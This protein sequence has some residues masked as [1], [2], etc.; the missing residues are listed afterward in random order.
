MQYVPVRFAQRV[1]QHPVADE[2]AVDEH[3]LAGVLRR[4]GRLHREA[5]DRERPRLGF[6]R[7]RP[8]DERAPEKR[9]D[10]RA[11]AVRLQAMQE[12]PVVLQREPDV[13][14]RQRN[15]A[16][17]FVAVAPLG[18]F[19]AQELAPRRRVEVELL[20]GHRRAC[21]DRRGRGGTD[22]AAVDLDAPRMRRVGRA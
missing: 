17:R 6:D 11:T 2:A 4:V 7:C 1:S 15:A 19:R 3:V 12:P 9:R 14:M 10:A 16:E 18:G 13:G 8:F 20:R 5:R 22:V 21:G